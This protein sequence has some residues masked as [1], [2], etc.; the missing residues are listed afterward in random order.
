MQTPLAV[1]LGI[2]FP[3]FA[4][5]HCR[6]VVAAVTN[7]GGVG[8]LGSTRQTPNELRID[9]RWIEEAVE[10]RPYGVD[11]LFPSSSAADDEREAAVQIPERFREFVD[12][13]ME[14]FSIP[15]PKDAAKYSRSGDNLIPTHERARQKLA[16]AMEHNPPLVASA[17]GPLPP[18]IRDDLKDRGTKIIGLV[19]APGQASRHVASGADIIVATGTEAGG[20]TGE[21]ST[22]VLVPQVVDEVAPVPVLAAGGIAD[23]RQIAAVVALG[24]Q[25]VWTGSLWL[26]A[27][28]SD[29]EDVVKEKLV[30]ATSRD[31]VRSR[32][33]TGKP[34]RQLRTEWVAAWDAP[35]APGTLPAPL[36]GVLVREMMTGI[37][38]H[39]VERAMG[40]AV[41]QNVGML[42]GVRPSR[43]IMF[44]L[45][46]G[47]VDASSRVAELLETP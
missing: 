32:C 40:T 14:R 17:L 42:H 18:D 31:T 15:P 39:N 37:F 22:L 4:F 1:A 16:V 30:A 47:Y 5:S 13:L 9:L 33:L 25:G 10:G 29:L 28:E 27:A 46:N 3:I 2:E 19:G 38:D 35:N 44:D 8:V 11:L 45:V 12:E 21:I 24:A 41:G 20:H 26:M 7:A 6:D 36:Q 43:Q 23:G 34:V